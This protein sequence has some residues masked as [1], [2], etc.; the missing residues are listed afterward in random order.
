VHTE[1]DLVNKYYENAS[2]INSPNKSLDPFKNQPVCS[3]SRSSKRRS[4]PHKIR[5]PSHAS[6]KK[7]SLSPVRIV[8][9]K[10]DNTYHYKLPPYVIESFMKHILN[11]DDSLTKLKELYE[12][13]PV[14][15]KPSYTI[16][17]YVN[18]MD[19]MIRKI[20]T[21][22]AI[23]DRDIKIPFDTSKYTEADKST[24]KH[25]T[26]TESMFDTKLKNDENTQTIDGIK[27]LGDTIEKPLNEISSEVKG[28]SVP[29]KDVK[30]RDMGY[31][32][33]DVFANNPSSLMLAKFKVIRPKH[34]GQGDQN[35]QSFDEKIAVGDGLKNEDVQTMKN[36][37][38][39][40]KEHT[41]SKRQLLLIIP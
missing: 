18:S 27:Q 13:L 7:K 25:Y 19:H 21:D 35:K 2:P 11:S 6:G 14:P 3:R 8:K 29:E 22:L 17:D 9:I 28:S 41:L 36:V 34:A 30:L 39:D 37:K 31:D 12:T 16:L 32:S 1:P 5:T 10:A 33:D 15:T 24:M 4:P 40:D 20:E 23:Q 38:F 26:D